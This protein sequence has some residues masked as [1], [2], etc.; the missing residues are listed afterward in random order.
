[1]RVH[2]ASKARRPKVTN[3]PKEIAPI[4]LVL[5]LRRDL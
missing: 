3:P 5:F 2:A 1:V 4:E